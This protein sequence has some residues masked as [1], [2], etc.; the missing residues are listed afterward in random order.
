[1]SGSKGR[2][3]LTARERA[4]RAPYVKNA[5][6]RTSFLHRRIGIDLECVEEGGCAGACAGST[7][8]VTCKSK[9]SPVAE[10]VRMVQFEITDLERSVD[11]LAVRLEGVVARKN[12]CSDDKSA[13]FPT[14]GTSPLA[15][16]IYGQAQRLADLRTRVRHL[17]AA[18]EL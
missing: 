6:E 5:E 1:M 4:A 18:I 9:D 7:A 13:E 17:S 11:E 3:A 14:T 8:E 16:D 15:C 2:A 10:A 12:A